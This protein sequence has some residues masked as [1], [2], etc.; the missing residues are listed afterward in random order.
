MGKLLQMSNNSRD[1]SLGIYVSIFNVLIQT[2]F[3]PLILEGTES[4]LVQRAHQKGN[5]NFPPQF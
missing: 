2:H 3:F 1:L 4:A 5:Q